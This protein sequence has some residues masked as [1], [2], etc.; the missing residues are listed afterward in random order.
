MSIAPAYPR[1][2]SEIRSKVDVRH[3]PHRIEGEAHMGE[4]DSEGTY[5]T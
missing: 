3:G 2:C 4:L 5:V 1:F